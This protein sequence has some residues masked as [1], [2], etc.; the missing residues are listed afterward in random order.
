MSILDLPFSCPQ[1]SVAVDAPRELERAAS[2]GDWIRHD[3][4]YCRFKSYDL[5]YALYSKFPS[6][7]SEEARS[8]LTNFV[9][10][11]AASKSQR[12]L[13]GPSPPTTPFF[14]CSPNLSSTHLSVPSSPPASPAAL[15]LLLGSV[16][17]EASVPTSRPSKCLVLL[18]QPACEA[19]WLALALCAVYLPFLASLAIAGWL[20]PPATIP[21]PSPRLLFSWW[22]NKISWAPPPHIPQGSKHWTPGTTYEGGWLVGSN[23]SEERHWCPWFCFYHTLRAQYIYFFCCV[24]YF[25]DYYFDVVWRWLS[26]DC[27]PCLAFRW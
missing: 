13:S 18:P 9:V 11:F 16:A 7:G 27:K 2:F 22:R 3:I 25:H 4:Q 1:A 14:F 5:T 19:V 26:C 17:C 20:L 23:S 6:W 10:V 8:P 21:N 24:C 12:R 15:L